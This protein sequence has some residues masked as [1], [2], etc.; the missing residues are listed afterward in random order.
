M[1]ENRSSTEN[2]FNRFRKLPVLPEKDWKTVSPKLEQLKRDEE[3]R[4]QEILI[5]RHHNKIR[6]NRL[7]TAS[8]IE[9]ATAAPQATTTVPTGK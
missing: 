8:V 6:N 9:P 2:E 3:K 7:G 4:E 1:A 5:E